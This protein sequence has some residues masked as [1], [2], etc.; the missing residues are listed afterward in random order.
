MIL[1][2]RLINTADAQ[3]L[4]GGLNGVGIKK[5]KLSFPG[6]MLMVSLKQPMI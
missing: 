6:V 4:S 3:S 1:E 5:H 2:Q